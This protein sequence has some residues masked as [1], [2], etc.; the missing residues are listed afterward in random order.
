M[1]GR[2]RERFF[3]ERTPLFESLVFLFFAAIMSG[4]G[5]LG[6]AH[7]RATVLRPPR[8]PARVAAT[9]ATSTPAADPLA[10]LPRALPAR[11]RL[12]FA[13]GSPPPPLP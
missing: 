10:G 4:H 9:P 2:L 6:H 12:P 7:W 8:I 13:P 5:G 1:P 3:G 11:S